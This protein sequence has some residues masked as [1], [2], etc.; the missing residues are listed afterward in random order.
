MKSIH[1]NRSDE[2]IE[3]IL[4]TVF[5]Q[6]AQCLRNSSESVWRVSQ[7]LK[8][9]GETRSDWEFGINGY[10]D[11]IFP[12]ANP[13]AQTDAEVQGNLLRGYEQKFAELSEQQK[14]TK[15]FSNAGFSKNRTILH[16]T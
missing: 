1:F 14:L 3:L 7:R 5:R 15:L 9:Y 16:Y 6:S 8:R 12:T 4:P 11:R 10:T 2:T 13:I